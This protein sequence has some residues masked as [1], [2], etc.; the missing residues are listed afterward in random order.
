MTQEFSN[1]SMRV[2]RPGKPHIALIKGYWRVSPLPKPYR[3]NAGERWRDAYG[4]VM[5]LNNWR[6]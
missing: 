5:T 6:R 2:P 4:L 3:N 1:K